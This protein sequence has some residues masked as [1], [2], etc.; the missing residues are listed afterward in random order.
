MIA[1]CTAFFTSS[2]PPTSANVTGG[3]ES[4]TAPPALVGRPNELHHPAEPQAVVDLVAQL[5]G[6][7]EEPE[8]ELGVGEGLCPVCRPASSAARPAATS[9]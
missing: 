2:S 8:G 4:R 6:V 1:R 7:L 3:P 5:G 9:A